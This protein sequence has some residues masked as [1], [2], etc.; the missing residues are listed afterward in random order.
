M[1]KKQIIIMGIIV[2]IVIILVAV[3]VIFIQKG[4]GPNIDITTQEDLS[5]RM[6]IDYGGSFN[7]FD[8]DVEP[9][10][11]TEG[12]TEEELQKQTKQI[13]EE[14]EANLEGD[15]IDAE[16]NVK[17]NVEGKKDSSFSSLKPSKDATNEHEAELEYD[18]ENNM[19]LPVFDNSGYAE[20][21]VLCDAA[22]WEEAE[23]IAKQ[24]SGTVL[25]CEN[26]VATIQIE[27]S[28]DALLEN[29]EKQGSTLELYR[30]YYYSVQ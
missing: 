11:D 30:N 14:F 8:T 7:E 24:I 18:E 4:K 20:N 29:L 13:Q 15:V 2:L 1:K 25:S 27:G 17:G 21:E 28:V 22:T 16:G 26:G 19:G 9:G 5:E 6:G 23:E 12:P 3:L 10:D